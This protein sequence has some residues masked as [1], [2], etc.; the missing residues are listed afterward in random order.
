LKLNYG[1]LKLGLVETGYCLNLV[2]EFS[3]NLRVPKNFIFNCY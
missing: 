3:Y 2:L 1:R